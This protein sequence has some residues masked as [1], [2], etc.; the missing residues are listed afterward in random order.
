MLAAYSEMLSLK[1]FPENYLKTTDL[2]AD[3]CRFLVEKAVL[4]MLRLLVIKSC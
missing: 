3:Y 2:Y 4:D 1:N